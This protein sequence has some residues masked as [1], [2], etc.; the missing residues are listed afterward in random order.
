MEIAGEL[1]DRQNVEMSGS[2]IVVVRML[3]SQDKVSTPIMG[4][5]IQG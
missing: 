4:N 2:I 1:Q 5:G 3:S